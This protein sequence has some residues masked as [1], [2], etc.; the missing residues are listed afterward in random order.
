MMVYLV[1]A[2]LFPTN[3]RAQSI[4]FC[5]MIARVFGLGASFVS[6]L[7]FIWSPLPSLVLGVPALVAA[8]FALGL[9]ETSGKD[10]PETMR[11]EQEE[12][13]EEVMLEGRKNQGY[14]NG[15]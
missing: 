9:K 4:G 13:K 2:E 12:K 8:G 15:F 10:L 3:L 1:T 14:Q 11:E 6:N 5:S 7:G